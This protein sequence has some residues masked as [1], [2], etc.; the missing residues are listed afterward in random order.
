MEY[1]L[2]IEPSHIIHT[3]F[4]NFRCRKRRFSDTYNY[5]GTQSH[6][7]DKMF[8]RILFEDFYGKIP[9]GF[10]I[11]HKDGNSLN[12]C[13]LNLQI[14]S[15]SEHNKI[16][17]KG[18]KTWVGR[19]H[20]EESKKKM[21]ESKKKRYVG[22]G[23]PRY[24]QDIPD[25]EKLYKEYLKLGSFASVSRKYKCSEACISKRIKKYLAEEV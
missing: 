20:K 7:Q 25:K 2:K 19:K 14:I 18:N 5:I 24:R 23:N 4:G 10:H 15:P 13:I 11:H 12:N 6:N 3:K 17:F 8:H 16:H 22:K 21:S 1:I 9:N